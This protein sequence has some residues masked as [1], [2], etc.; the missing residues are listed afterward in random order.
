[1]FRPSFTLNRNE[2]IG[3]IPVDG[4]IAGIIGILL[5]R[6]GLLV[7]VFGVVVV[8]L[9]CWGRSKPK[10]GDATSADRHVDDT[11]TG[12]TILATF[13]AIG[14]WGVFAIACVLVY[15][16]LKAGLRALHK[17]ILKVDK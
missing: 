17:M 13:W 2:R 15:W 7:A 14:V 16:P 1:M 4:I 9:L 5:M 10:P 6:F 11:A 12:M 3:A 8:L